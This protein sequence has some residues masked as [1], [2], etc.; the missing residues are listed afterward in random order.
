MT[1]TRLGD[2]GH[3]V[4]LVVHRVEDVLADEGAGRGLVVAESAV[5][6]AAGAQPAG[7]CKR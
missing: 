5:E 4:D 7:E 1:S 2:P 3:Q 6:G